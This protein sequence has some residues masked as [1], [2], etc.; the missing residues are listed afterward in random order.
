VEERALAALA[1]RQH[2]VVSAAQLHA[3]GLG[4][5][6]V[7]HRVAAGRLHR[8]HRGVYAVGHTALGAGG[9]RMAAVLACGPGAALSHR[10]AGA[11]WGLRPTARA[12]IEVSTPRRARRER[13]GI[14][15][16]R[17]RNLP[18]EDVT[19]V[20]GVPVTT[21][22]RTL[23]DLA[24]VLPADALARAVHEAEVLRL[25]DVAAVEAVLARSGG[26]RGTGRLRA[27]LAAP[28][29]GPVRS[30][31]EERFLALCRGGG[32][33]A[34]RTN[35]WLPVDSGLVEVDAFFPHARVVVELDGA[36]AHRTRRAFDADRRRD[37]AL[38]ARGLLV[39]RLTWTR[40]TREREA[41]VGE[42]R[43]IL[44]LRSAG[45]GPH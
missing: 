32:L 26:R 20:D 31:L 22:A 12:R 18:A 4:P 3:L 1:A 25:L 10:S 40:V 42:L 43:R 21:V 5:R 29:T 15:V 7:T 39:I 13:P 11:A 34:P 16:H 30:V 27:L 41:V 17:V 45:G 2:G 37:S 38:A 23:V 36:A 14:E 35:V 8:L 24:G 33:P 9:R 44:A 19:E 28:A 6:G